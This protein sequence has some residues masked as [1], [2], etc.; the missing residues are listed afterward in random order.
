MS[1]QVLQNDH[2]LYLFR[3]G[4]VLWSQQLASLFVDK[5][6]VGHKDLLGEPVGHINLVLTD[7]QIV[8]FM[9]K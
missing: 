3:K 2:T 7:V 1:R 9:A 6:F 4:S 8:V 5:A